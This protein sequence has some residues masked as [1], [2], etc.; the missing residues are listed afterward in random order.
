MKTLTAT[1][2]FRKRVPTIAVARV[3]SA[4]AES[5]IQWSD[6]TE[7]LT[8]HLHGKLINR[9]FAGTFATAMRTI[10]AVLLAF[11]GLLFRL[12]LFVG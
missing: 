8:E 1:F 7:S 6:N 10:A 9:G 11:P 3:A 4:C 2:H 5:K 12:T